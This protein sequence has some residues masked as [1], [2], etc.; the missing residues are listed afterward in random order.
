[1]DKPM[2]DVFFTG[3]SLIF[4]VRDWIRPPE[5]VL[6]EVDLRQGHHVLDFGCG[7]GAFSIAAARQVGK[8]G[9][10]YA[11]DV[12]PKAIH[13][14]RERATREGLKNISTILSDNPGG[15]E[16][17]S[18]DVV[19]LYDIFH[20]LGDGHSVLEELHRVLKPDALLSFSDHHMK[21]ERILSD[22]TA[23]GLFRLKGRGKR[24]YSFLKV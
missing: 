2:P 1:M 21:Q 16:S 12:H 3:M 9:R 11:L 24:T 22:V 7:P 13:K 20:M 10:V 15:V 14:V 8:S 18:V 17:E 4:Q 19:L 23:D 6:A 5:K